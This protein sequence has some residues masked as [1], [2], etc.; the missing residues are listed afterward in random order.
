MALQL[1][2]L[3]GRK[4]GRFLKVGSSPSVFAIYQCS[5]TER[6]PVRPLYCST[7]A[8]HVRILAGSYFSDYEVANGRQG[9][10]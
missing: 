2:P 9:L 3:R 10:W 1:T 6:Q 8:N 4:I 7:V 5:A